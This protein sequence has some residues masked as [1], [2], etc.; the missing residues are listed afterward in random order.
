MREKIRERE[1]GNSISVIGA[2]ATLVSLGRQTPLRTNNGELEASKAED[3]FWAPRSP[4]FR[5]RNYIYSN[6]QKGQS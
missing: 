4:P 6:G 3:Q 2:T 5:E 1:S